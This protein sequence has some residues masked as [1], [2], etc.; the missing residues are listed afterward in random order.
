[1]A[2]NTPPA[3]TLLG[4]D[5]GRK[6]IGVAVGQQLTCSASPLTTVSARDGKPDWPAIS[7]L[8]DEWKP[9]ALVVG[10]PYHMDGTEQD[11]T[12]AAQRF[13]RQLEGRYQL[14]VHH[15]EER[16]TSYVVESSLNDRTG[17]MAIDPLS[18]Q[19]ILQDWLQHNA[20][21]K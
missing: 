13:G 9:D 14:P 15:A 8:L 4:F 20:L 19:V 21:S 3:Q 17:K 11:M 6:R 12:R 1:M 2:E 5:Y 10:I 7:R 16:L 18:A